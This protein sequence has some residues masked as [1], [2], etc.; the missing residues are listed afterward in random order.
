MIKFCNKCGNKV[1]SAFPPD[2]DR[3]RLVCQ[4]CGFVHYE[5]PKMVVGCIPVWKDE[6]LLVRRA[7]E[8]RLGK[9]TLPAGYLEN[10]ET[11]ADG[12]RRETTEEAGADTGELI[13]YGL[14]N[15]TPVNQIYMIFRTDLLHTDFRGGTESLE[16]KLF[17]ESDI[18]WDEMAFKVIQVSLERFLADRIRG[19]YPFHTDDINFVKRS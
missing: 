9:W 11:V 19:E 1:A 6:I 12:A 5:N 2:E 18:P 13:P 7:I 3:E 10:G 8:P 16:V 15:L 4:S 14:Y 17:K